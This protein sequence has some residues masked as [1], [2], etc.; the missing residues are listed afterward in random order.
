MKIKEKLEQLLD[1]YY[2]K[3]GIFASQYEKQMKRACEL[4][5]IKFY[6]KY[7]Y[8][9]HMNLLFQNKDNPDV[10]DEN[11]VSVLPNYTFLGIPIKRLV[12]HDCSNGYCYSIVL[13]LSLCFDDFKIVTAELDNYA[14]YYRNHGHKT[15]YKHC[16]LL[17]PNDT[18]VDTTFGIVCPKEIYAK[19]FKPSSCKYI[20]SEEL[21]D[22]DLYQYIQEL[23]TSTYDKIFPQFKNVELGNA[24]DTDEYW[25]FFMEWQNKNLAYKNL[26]N[27]NMEDYF[28]KHISRTSNPHCLWNWHLSVLYHPS[29]E[30]N[31][32]KNTINNESTFER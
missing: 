11:F 24:M 10:L 16:F 12:Q 28:T 14:E 9:S 25:N 6:D 29:Q 27:S 2:Y 20:T 17:L 1:D 21:K 3:E 32:N 31:S 5:K 30:Y 23:K 26:Q 7:N 8:D 18:V 19:I 22:C 4:G 15:N 13:A